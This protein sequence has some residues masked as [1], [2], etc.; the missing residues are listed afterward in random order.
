L[1]EVLIAYKNFIRRFP[2]DELTDQAFEELQDIIR[3]DERLTVAEVLLLY[4]FLN[5]TILI[6]SK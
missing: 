6:W 2:Q 3:Y 1:G 5:Q 4:D